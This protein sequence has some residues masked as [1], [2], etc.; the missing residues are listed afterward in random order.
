[1]TGER[2]L[3]IL[4]L[5]GWSIIELSRRTNIRERTLRRWIRN[6]VPVP[7]AVAQWLEQIAVIAAQYPPPPGRN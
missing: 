5:A 4:A 6:E 1:M 2:V 7:E 3:E